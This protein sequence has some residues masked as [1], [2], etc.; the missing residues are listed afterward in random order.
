MLCQQNFVRVRSGER[1]KGGQPG[2]QLGKP[3][4]LHGVEGVQLIFSLFFIC[5]ASSPG[6]NI[7]ECNE[8]SLTATGLLSKLALRP[9]DSAAP[10]SKCF[11]DTNSRC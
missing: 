10:L 11:Q 5:F 1:V 4:F 8:D 2:K 6:N 9:D 7:S 3:S